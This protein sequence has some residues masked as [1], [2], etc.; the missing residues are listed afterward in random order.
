[1]YRSINITDYV[2]IKEKKKINDTSFQENSLNFKL[3]MLVE[4]S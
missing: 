4:E 3:A 1:V 2:E